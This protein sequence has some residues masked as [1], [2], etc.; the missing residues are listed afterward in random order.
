LEGEWN[1]EPLKRSVRRH[2]DQS[3]KSCDALCT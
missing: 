1:R 3:V 2:P